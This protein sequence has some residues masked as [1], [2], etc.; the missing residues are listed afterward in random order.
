MASEAEPGASEKKNWPSGVHEITY[1]DL[2]RLGVGADH[3]LY[4]D[5]LPVRTEQ[6]LALTIFQSL[7]AI[8]AAAAITLGGL[9]GFVLGV[10]AAHDFGC[11]GHWWQWGCERALEQAPQSA[12]STQAKRSNDS[13][14]NQ[15]EHHPD[16]GASTGCAMSLRMRSDGS[17]LCWTGNVREVPRVSFLLPVSVR[18]G[19]LVEE[20]EHQTAT[21]VR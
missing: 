19:K 20:P 11:A 1:A 8:A 5:G 2:G 6:R 15:R 3:R 7:I 17:Y 16:Q 9:G 12:P 10:T 21:G 4:W 18:G 13:A 14:F